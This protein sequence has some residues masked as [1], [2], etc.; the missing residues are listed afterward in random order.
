M[1]HL[2]PANRHD[3]PVSSEDDSAKAKDSLKKILFRNP[4]ADDRAGEKHDEH[5][6]P[7]SAAK[8]LM[9]LAHQLYGLL[10]KPVDA[11]WRDA[12][13]RVVATNGALGDF[14]WV[15]CQSRHRRSTRKPCRSLPAT[16][17]CRGSLAVMPLPCYDIGWRRPRLTGPSSNR[18]I[19]LQ[20]FC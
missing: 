19:C 4:L 9:S 14:R 6:R 2:G 13:S 15:C 11:G 1:V 12:K 5:G 10:L 18:S 17:M 16:A 3:R 7:V 20:H 8:G